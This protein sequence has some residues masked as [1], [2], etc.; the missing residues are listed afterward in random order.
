MRTLLVLA[1]VGCGSPS[2]TPARPPDPGPEQQAPPPVEQASEKPPEFR[3]PGDVRPTRY[4]LEL[5]IDPA[6]PRATGVNRIAAEVVKPTRVVWVH[7]TGLE[8]SSATLGGKPARVVPGGEDFVGLAADRELAPGPLV[9]EIA[10]AAPIDPEKS[11]GLYSEKEGGDSYAYTFFEPVDAR[12]AFPC[13]DEPAY[14][15]PWQL[16]FHVAKGHVAL[17]N[18]AVVKET[19]EANGMKRVELAESKPL[20]SYLVAFVVGPFE[21]VDGGTAGRIKTPVRFII[22]KG[23]AAELRYAKSITPRV[24]AALE[25]YFDMDYPYGK[26]DVAVVPRFW[27][28][29]EHPGIVAMGQ[30]LTLIRADEETRARKQAYTNILAHELAHYWFGDVVTMRWWDDTWLNEALAQWL[31]AT[32]TDAVEPG[33]RIRDARIGQAVAAMESDETLAVR[34]IR[35]PVT[36]REAIEASFDNDIVYGKGAS[37]LRMFE[38]QDATKFRDFIR[39]FIKKHAWGNA[40]SEDLFAVMRD[41]LGAPIETAFRTFVDQPGVPLVATKFRCTGGKASLALTQ[42]RALPAG[43]VDP[44]PRLWDVRFCAR[45]G[46]GAKSHEACTQLAAANGTLELPMAGCP[47]WVITNGGANGY[48]RSTADPKIAKQLFGKTKLAA[49]AKPTPAEKMM[50]VADLRVMVDREEL[51]LDQLLPLVPAIA[52]DPDEKV[53]VW[54][55][56]ASSFTARALDD[57]MYAKAKKFW[58]ATFGGPARKLGWTRAKTDSDERHELRRTFVPAVGTLDPK[59]R[60]DATRLAVRWLGDRKGLE[61]DMVGPVLGTAAEHGDAA[62]FDKVL[63]ASAK[64]RDRRDQARLL[65]ALAGFHDPALVKRALDLVLAKDRDIRETVGIVF[66]LLFQRETSAHAIEFITANIDTMLG[67]M[68]DDGAAG[69]LAALAGFGCTPDRLKQMRALVEPRAKKYG[70]AENYVTRGFEQAQQCITRFE[71]ELPALE[72][73]FAKY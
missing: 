53:A 3:L 67:R 24:I 36:T 69:F 38:A 8:I 54:A 14:K 2:V 11:R 57:A 37:I 51:Q 26:L 71:R 20:P 5:T 59:L 1:L 64:G 66:G 68:R 6:K 58:L 72:R 62:L 17:G 63:A 30:P 41:K 18:T 42:R 19:D 60:A 45:Y 15:V 33:W 50:M 52:S 27:G 35:Q 43:T 28:T 31:D 13:F 61:D 32:I 25:D 47:T 9:I 48:Y 7:A 16:T 21:V 44:K 4:A 12:R 73:V 40:T 65:G 46:D 55:F 10:F 29:M 22:P 49:V 34:A 70:G 39:T 56:A 23:R